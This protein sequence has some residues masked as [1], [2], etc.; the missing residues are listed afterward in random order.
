MMQSVLILYVFCSK[1][2]YLIFQGPCSHIFDDVKSAV[3]LK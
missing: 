1:T 3:F 2:S